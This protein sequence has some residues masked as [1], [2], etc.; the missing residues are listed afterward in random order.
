MFLLSETSRKALGPTQP[1]IQWIE[2][3]K[4]QGR[5]IKPLIS[6]QR[7]SED[8]GGIHLLHLSA[9]L[10]GEHNDSFTFTFSFKETRTIVT[11]I[12]QPVRIYNKGPGFEVYIQSLWKYLGGT[13]REIYRHLVTY[14][15]PISL[16]CPVSFESTCQLQKC[17]REAPMNTILRQKTSSACYTV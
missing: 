16:T 11:Y 15:C 13:Y 6:I 3:V 1:P 8:Y 10:C 5:E 2:W 4:L 14:N 17:Y 7:R 12:R 9:F